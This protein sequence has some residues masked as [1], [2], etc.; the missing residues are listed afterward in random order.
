MMKQLKEKGY[1]EAIPGAPVIESNFNPPPSDSFSQANIVNNNDSNNT[2]SS[3][4]SNFSIPF[5]S[6]NINPPNNLSSFNATYGNINDYDDSNNNNFNNCPPHFTA[7]NDNY[8]I[9]T[10][11][12]QPSTTSSLPNNNNSNYEG[13]IGE[14][15]DDNDDDDDDGE[16]GTKASIAKYDLSTFYPFYKTLKEKIERKS[17][18]SKKFKVCQAYAESDN[19]EGLQKALNEVI[20]MLKDIEKVK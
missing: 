9:A 11:P 18:I 5:Q 20:Q 8:K 15:D 19:K 13:R 16:A 1:C 17:D 12:F 14:D 10:S 3:Y 6:T 7:N 4:V 2:D